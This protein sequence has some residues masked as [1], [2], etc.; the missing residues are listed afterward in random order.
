MI[1]YA[2]THNCWWVDQD[3]LNVFCEGRVCFLDDKWNVTVADDLESKFIDKLPAD[4]RSAYKDNCK[5]AYIYHFVS[6]KKPWEKPSGEFADI[7]W[8]AA[9]KTPWYETIVE[10][11]K[12]FEFIG[13][14]NCPCDNSDLKSYPDE[15]IDMLSLFLKIYGSLSQAVMQEDFKEFMYFKKEKFVRLFSK[16]RLIFYGAG[17]ACRKILRCFNELDIS[18]PEKIW[19]KDVEKNGKSLFGIEIVQP[20]FESLRNSENILF[21]IA[22]ENETITNSIIEK[23]RE[24]SF[25]GYMTEKH[26]IREIAGLLWLRWKHKWKLK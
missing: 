23:L 15:V 6:K 20:D 1:E 2:L 9:R 11:I 16:S 24:R 3:V 21:V 19:D 5:D 13:F 7:F 14:L 22:I 10:C 18:L 4:M 25:V 12:S 17:E 26:V 8:T